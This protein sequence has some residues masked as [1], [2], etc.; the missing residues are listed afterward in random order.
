ELEREEGRLV[1]SFDLAVTGKPGVEEVLIDAET[2]EV[3]SQ[4]YETPA[5]EARE[6]KAD[7][8][9]RDAG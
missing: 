1:Y 8:A 9:N 3:V 2:G 7:Q 6:R 5:A 4:K